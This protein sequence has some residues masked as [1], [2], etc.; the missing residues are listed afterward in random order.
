MGEGSGCEVGLLDDLSQS[1]DQGWSLLTHVLTE[2]RSLKETRE[3]QGK[4]KAM[5]GSDGG[6]GLR[7]LNLSFTF[8]E[9]LG[10]L[11]DDLTT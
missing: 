7:Q 11:R 8:L 10:G 2:Q 3:I 6:G 5:G 4:D 1:P 9:R